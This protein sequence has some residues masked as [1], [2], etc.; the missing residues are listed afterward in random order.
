VADLRRGDDH[1]PEE[2]LRGLLPVARLVSEALK[3]GGEGPELRSEARLMAA[4]AR[5]EEPR[6]VPRRRS[7]ALPAFAIT[8]WVATVV[9]FS[10]FSYQYGLNRNYMLR[11]AAI[12]MS[13]AEPALPKITEPPLSP[14]KKKPTKHA[15]RKRSSHA[16]T[17]ASHKPTDEMPPPVRIDELATTEDLLND[18]AAAPTDG[19]NSPEGAQDNLMKEGNVQLSQGQWEKAASSFEQA[20]RQNPDDESALD[21][22]HLSGAIAERALNNPRRAGEMYRQEMELARRMLERREADKDA[23]PTEPVKQ[24]LARAMTYVGLMERDPQMIRRAAQENSASTSADADP[25]N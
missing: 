19:T 20:A 4:I 13:N 22:L 3:G 23:P 12:Q 15:L 21:A 24:R 6:F 5:S 7:W 2:D 11:L 8:G 14:T 10:L 9:G 17:E 25:S 16:K 1:D 18:V